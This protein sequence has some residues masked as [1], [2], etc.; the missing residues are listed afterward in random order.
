M[1]VN[2]ELKSGVILDFCVFITFIQKAE[3][4]PLFNLLFRIRISHEIF[5]CV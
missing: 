3:I 2:G 5:C 1:A 4:T